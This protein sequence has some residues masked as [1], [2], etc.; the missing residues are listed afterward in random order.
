MGFKN[1]AVKLTAKASRILSAVSRLKTKSQI[2]PKDIGRFGMRS[3][4]Y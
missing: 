3:A 2:C 1:Q 4:P